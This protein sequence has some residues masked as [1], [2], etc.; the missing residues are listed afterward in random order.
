[1][2]KL[3][4]SASIGKCLPLIWTLVLV[5]AAG[6]NPSAQSTVK[7]VGGTP[8]SEFVNGP[9]GTA[10]T[11]AVEDASGEGIANAT[12]TFGAPTA[13]PSALFSAATCIT[14][15][16]GRCH[17]TAFANAFVGSYDVTATSSGVSGGATFSLMNQASPNLVVTSAG[18]EG[19]NAANCTVQASATAGT[20]PDCSLRDALLEAELLHSGH[21]GFDATHFAKPTTITLSGSTPMI[22][23]L[24]SIT[25]P[26]SGSGAQLRNLITMNGNGLTSV[27]VVGGATRAVGLSNLTITGATG[28]AVVNHGSLAVTNC[29]FH[30]N[31]LAPGGEGGA[32]LNDYFST[33]VVSGSTFWNNGGTA[34]YDNTGGAIYNVL[35]AV[36]TV[37][38]STFTGNMAQGWGGAIYNDGT[39]TISGSTVADNVAEAGGGIVNNGAATISNTILTGDAPSDCAGIGCTTGTAYLQVS[40]TVTMA[41]SGEISVV[42]KDSLGKEYSATAAYQGASTPASIATELSSSFG[43][44]AG[45]AAQA[46]GAVVVLQAADGASS[47]TFTITNPSTFKIA[48]INEKQ[49]LNGGGN[50]VGGTADLAPLGNYGGPTQTMVPLPG[51]AAI[52]GGMGSLIA[53]G[54]TIDQRGGPNTNTT[55]PGFSAEAP[56][57]DAGAVQTQYAMSF[58]AQPPALVNQNQPMSPAPAVTLSESGVPA[59]DAGDGTTGGS[60]LMTDSEGVLSGTTAATLNQGFAKFTDLLVTN[61]AANDELSASLTL[62]PAATLT[63]TAATLMTTRTVPTITWTTPAPI[64]YGTALSATQLDATAN[65]GGTFKYSPAAGTVLKAGLQTLSVT[66]T[67]ADTTDYSTTTATVTLTVNQ[68]TPVITWPTPAPIAYGTPLSATQ[69]DAKTGG[70][71]GTFTYSPS[72][73]SVLSAG[74]Y[75]LFTTFTPTDTQDLTTATATV[76]L[77]VNPVRAPA[78]TFTPAAAT[79][80]SP[81]Q[82]TINS[83]TPGNAYPATIYYTTNGSTPNPA[84]SLV[85]TQPIPVTST[86]TIKAI[87]VPP[88]SSSYSESSVGTAV[89]SFAPATLKPSFSPPAGTYTKPQSVTITDGTADASIFYTTDETIPTTSSTPYTGAIAVNGFETIRALAIASGHSQSAYGVSTYTLNLPQAATPEVL[90]DS[91]SYSGTQTVTITDATPGATIYYTLDGTYPGTYSPVYSNPFAVTSATTVTAAA[92]APGYGL[93]PDATS[94]I[95]LS[96]NPSHLIYTVAGDETQGYSGD[97]VL[98]TTSAF[99]DIEN[100]AR[101]AAGNLYIAD[102]GNNRIRKVAAGTGIV[103]TIAGTGTAGY[104]GDNGPA[105][106]AQIYQPWGIVVGS[107]GNIY[108]SDVGNGR[109]RK[110]T[111]S[112][113]I[114]TTVAASPSIYCPAGL[115]IDKSNNLYVAESCVGKVA[116]I[117][118]ANGAV[119]NFAGSGFWGYSGD[120]GAAVNADLR[121]PYGVAVDASGNVYIADSYNQ[122]IR[123]V[124]AGSGVITTVAGNGTDAGDFIGTY[125]G[126][127]GPATSAELS[128]PDGVAVDKSGNLYIADTWNQRVREVNA[129]TGAITTFAGDGNGCYSS[130]WDGNPA[131]EVGLCYPAGVITDSVGDVYIANTYYSTLREV[132]AAAGPPTAVTATPVA[133]LAAGPYSGPQTVTLSDSTPGAAIYVTL[134]GS[135]PTTGSQQY[136]GPIQL[137]GSVTLRAIALAPKYLSS[138]PISDQYTITS[139]PASVISTYAGSGLYGFSGFGGL[140]TKA[141]LGY[142]Y[143]LAFDS[144]GNLFV[145]DEGNNVVWKITAATGKINVVAGIGISGYS[146]DSGLATRAELS[147]PQSIAVDAQ[148]NLYIADTANQRVR[149]VSAATGV[150]TTVAGNGTNNNNGDGGLATRAGVVS[151]EA[152]AL[153]SHGNLYIAEE[154]AAVREVSAETGIIS[155]FAGNGTYGYGGDGGLATSATLQNP[156]AIAVDGAGNVYIADS[157]RIRKV[158]AS[159]G[160]ISTIAGIGDFGCNGD[161]GPATEALLYVDVSGLAVDA[162]GNLYF[163]DDGEI[164]EISAGTGIISAVAGNNYGGFRGD[165]GSATMAGI[166]NPYG[167]AL[168]SSGNLYIADQSDYRVRKVTFST[169]EAGVPSEASQSQP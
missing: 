9:F 147:D 6:P 157:G 42:F 67:P 126:D 84:T 36:M 119:T 99:D 49:I 1:M 38:S 116:E 90:P 123:K 167:V 156:L 139:P 72:A 80:T 31:T 78:P 73:G 25:G 136:F 52:C 127:G 60:V 104:S 13:G 125:G 3:I 86:T 33:L 57:V 134:D 51:S 29:T 133:S 19:G 53:A 153:D 61:T 32:I 85:F 145:A 96:G 155:T 103:T 40:G 109:V 7:A 62:S 24:T 108:F 146:G 130:V 128:Q 120:G 45:L 132:P 151:P 149:M 92:I 105:A 63:A 48:K 8:Q 22:Y 83:S 69:L 163:S 37:D 66:F 150:I 129:S 20:D 118:A 77:T 115:A 143:G 97:G 79:Y 102:E 100:V 54:L 160:I 158:T 114:I 10:L 112:T 95:L 168:D 140:A 76:T 47:G 23:S 34:T 64:T 74:T 70:A 11:A 65:V 39:M 152:I 89:F 166:T 44:D 165:G 124:T 144:S 14:N 81:I 56:C 15:T 121:E 137:T 21:I 50:V 68:K 87:A 27:F 28:G 164:R 106:A 58:T 59:A 18:N 5:A 43:E 82:V 131:D 12:V 17:V 41:E 46:F 111:V 122:V 162:A 30:G 148:G 154:T 169:A 55:Y 88:T 161:G 159:T 26:T 110:I 4:R 35:G 16:H 141:A 94:A 101:D 142:I 71:A 98:A 75:S 117:S 138:A 135:T 113:G 93:S 107:S 91:G 2:Q